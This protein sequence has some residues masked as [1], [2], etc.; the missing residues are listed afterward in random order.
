M[1]SESVSIPPVGVR[2]I[3]TVR[4]GGE[5]ACTSSRNSSRYMRVVLTVT[6]MSKARKD[7]QPRSDQLE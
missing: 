2:R 6:G 4:L 1:A 5:K 3:G 7:S